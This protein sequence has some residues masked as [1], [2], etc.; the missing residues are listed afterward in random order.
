MKEGPDL[1]LGGGFHILNKY[2]VF[3]VLNHEQYRLLLLIVHAL[4]NRFFKKS[5]TTTSVFNYQFVPGMQF[6]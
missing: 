1:Y 6:M 3:L 4:I 5:K 2:S